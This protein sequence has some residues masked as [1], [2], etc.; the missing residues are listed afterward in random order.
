MLERLKAAAVGALRRRGIAEQVLGDAHREPERENPF[1]ARPSRRPGQGTQERGGC[2]VPAAHA[3]VR[4]RVVKTMSGRISRMHRWC[5]SGHSALPWL[6]QGR[7]LRF[8]S[9]TLACA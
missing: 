5:S 9:T 6:L 4:V 2:R 7:Q 3:S 1:A 8:R